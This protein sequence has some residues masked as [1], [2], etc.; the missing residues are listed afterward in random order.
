[1]ASGWVVPLLAGIVAAVFAAKVWGQWSL[2]RRPHQLAWAIGLSLYA[3]AT[4]LDAYAAAE[5]WSVAVYRAFFAVAA[6]NVG[7]LGLGTILLTRSGA[8]GRIFA[9]FVAAGALLAAVGQFAIPLEAA[10]LDGTARHVPFP[11]PARW[12]FLL[13]NVVGGLALIGGAALSWWQT[14]RAGVL[15]IGVGAM[16]P[17]L[18]GS[19]STLFAL[20][21]RVLMQFLGIVVMFLGYLRGRETLPP[22]TQG[23]PVEG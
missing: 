4:L 7:F 19:I 20:D 17:F 21:L 13:L 5:G 22:A 2:R 9:L 15:L 11:Q 8:W 3:I 23:G 6:S 16:L 14:R 10:Q 1:M 18:G 12:A